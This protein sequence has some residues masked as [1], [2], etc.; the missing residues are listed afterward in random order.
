MRT[1]AS[2]ATTAPRTLKIVNS[3]RSKRFAGN[4]GLVG[5][6]VKTSVDVITDVTTIRNDVW[7]SH[8]SA[9]DPNF[10]LTSWVQIQFG[11]PRGLGLTTTQMNDQLLA[12]VSMLDASSLANLAKI[13][14]SE[15]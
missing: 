14:N 2:L 1:V 13:L 6:T 11:R 9:A 7:H 4:V 10:E 5:T 12:L 8:T 15:P 3:Q